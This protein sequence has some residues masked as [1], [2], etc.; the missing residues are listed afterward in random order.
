M[1][2]TQEEV[3][4]T[5]KKSINSPVI[6]HREVVCKCRSGSRAYGDTHICLSR[7]RDRLMRLRQDVNEGCLDHLSNI[8]SHEN[9]SLP[10]HRDA[11]S[12]DE[13]AR[14]LTNA[15]TNTHSRPFLYMQAG[16]D[17]C[18]ISHRSLINWQSLTDIQTESLHIAGKVGGRESKKRAS[19]EGVRISTTIHNR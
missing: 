10:P 9:T 16:G 6:C 7:G 14:G 13:T 19:R 4:D 18:V 5:E 12:S 1:L 3:C 2:L 8:L 11:R 15:I 17:S